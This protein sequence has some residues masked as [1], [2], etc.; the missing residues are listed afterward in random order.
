M[1]AGYNQGILTIIMS[2]TQ[3][4]QEFHCAQ[5]G[6]TLQPVEGQAFLSCPYCGS[7]VYL[8]RSKVVFHWYVE[9]T[10]APE[11]AAA[12]LRR[13]M[14]GNQ[15]VKD[16]DSRAQIGAPVFQYFPL[17]YVRGKDLQTGGK[18]QMFIEPAAATSITEIKSLHLPAADLKKYDAALDSQAV[19]PSVPFTALVGWLDQRG[20]QQTEIVEAALVHL[21]VYLFKYQYGGRTYSALVEAASGKVFANLFPAKAESP[22]FMVAALSTIGFLIISGLPVAGYTLLGESGL[23]FG[24]LGLLVTGGLFG[25]LVFGA[26]AWVSAK[27]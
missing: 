13:W 8:D 22:Y 11:A 16:L 19:Q 25:A 18:E 4:T 24:C 5:C 1:P 12:S 17:W 6:G 2:M 20:I 27:V 7:A 14:A 23:L 9:S 15:T 10:V 21:P 26:A 3:T